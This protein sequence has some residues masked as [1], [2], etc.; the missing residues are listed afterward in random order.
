M[1]PAAACLRFAD[2]SE[3][4]GKSTALDEVGHPLKRLQPAHNWVVQVLR[5]SPE[6]GM[7]HGDSDLTPT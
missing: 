5:E 7:F 2:L 6:L 1:R 3:F 4:L